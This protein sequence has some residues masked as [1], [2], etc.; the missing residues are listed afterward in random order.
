MA[1]RFLYNASAAGFTARLRAPIQQD[2]GVLAASAL[3]VSGGHS[4]ARV[5]NV[6]IGEIASVGAVSTQV[7]GIYSDDKKAWETLTMAT[8]EK[9]NVLDVVTVDRVSVRLVSHYPVDASEPSIHPI[10]T[11]FENLRVAGS[12]VKVHLDTGFFSELSTWSALRARVESDQ[13]LYRRIAATGEDPRVGLERGLLMCSLAGK[14]EIDSGGVTVSDD[15]V[16]DIP[17][18]GKLYLAEFVMSP[19]LRRITMLRM[20]LG[21]PVEGGVEGGDVVGNGHPYPP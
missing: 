9:L 18:F 16:I 2:T 17:H 13:D 8:I 12:D 19:Y 1:R 21:C 14:I 7:T 11:G 15:G 10:G 20:E 4:S 5:E 6:R 3:S